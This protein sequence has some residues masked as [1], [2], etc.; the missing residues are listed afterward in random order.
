MKE[1]KA[2]LLAVNGPQLFKYP[3]GNKELTEKIK[4]L[5]LSGAIKFNPYTMI[6]SK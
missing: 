2:I 6:W 4:A 1:V 5:E 3:A